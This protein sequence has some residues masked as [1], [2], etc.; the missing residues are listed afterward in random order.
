[1]IL[2][3]S[4][5]LAGSSVY[6]IKRS[7]RKFGVIET[8]GYKY[9][10]PSEVLESGVRISREDYFLIG[11]VKEGTLRIQ[12]STLKHSFVLTDFIHEIRV[13]FEGVLPNT[14]K[15]GETCRIQG[16]LVNEYNPIDFVASVIEGVH[17][18]ERTKNVYQLRSRDIVLKER[19]I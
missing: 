5:F 8:G 4:L 18:S 10:Q 2:V 17:D 11:I 19:P 7:G 16:N 13:N 6:L 15:E 12:E 1:M 3:S 14:L 9:Y